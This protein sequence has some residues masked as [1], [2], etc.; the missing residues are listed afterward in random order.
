M[1]IHTKPW[2]KLHPFLTLLLLLVF[3]GLIVTALELTNT[4]YFFHARPVEVTASP[5]TKGVPQ[6]KDS[7]KSN[8]TPENNDSSTKGDGKVDDTASDPN[9]FLKEPT[10]V[11]VSNHHPNLSGSP[12][13]NTINSV[14]NTTSGA[15]CQIIFTKGEE[16]KSLPAQMTDKGGATYWNGWKIQ[17]I[18]LT[19][20]E[21]HITA[22][23]ILGSQVKTADDALPLVVA[24]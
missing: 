6:S 22:K 19:K 24:Q 2:I 16:V 13:P 23:V 5:A 14:C 12:A 1:N 11:F 10:G 9:A 8:S 17:D 15:T 7:T 3:A 18:G 20:G 4:T 21:W